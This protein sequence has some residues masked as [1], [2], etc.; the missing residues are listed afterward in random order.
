MALFVLVATPVASAA[1]QPSPL[2]PGDIVTIVET[3]GFLGDF[4]L[5]K[6]VKVDPA[7]RVESTLS[8][9]SDPSQGPTAGP[10]LS[11]GPPPKFYAAVAVENT[12]AVFVAH[13]TFG[14]NG[15][16]ALFHV[17]PATGVRT[18]VSDFGDASQGPSQQRTFGIRELA[19]EPSGD[20]LVFYPG[21]LLIRV[22]RSTGMRTIVGD[23]Q[24]PA[25]GPVIEPTAL[26]VEE[27]GRILVGGLGGVVRVDPSTGTRALLSDFG[28]PEQGPSARLGSDLTVDP[29]GTILIVG[30]VTTL[31]PDPF[32]LLRVDPVTGTRSLVTELT[33]S[34]L[35]ANIPFDLAM[36]ETGDVVVVTGVADLGQ[37]LMRVDSVTG[38][39]AGRAGI[40]GFLKDVAVVPTPLVNGMVSLSVV[41]TTLEPS[42]ADP[43][44]PAGVFQITATLSNETATPIRN[45]FFRVAELSGGNV[46]VSGDGPPD[47]IRAGGKGTRQTPHVGIEG[48]L[49]PG[50]SVT[51]ELEIGLQTRQPFTFFVNVF[52]EPDTS[53]NSP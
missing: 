41:G 12:A 35:P 43:F 16:G 20:L 45:P 13:P 9:F 1:Q 39:C 50:E 34:T 7:T 17:D 28:N 30:P 3:A 47:L 33:C 18:I 31:P 48:V 24:D 11:P 27:S 22:N 15:Q 8:H 46:L 14:T 4:P 44:A 52:G 10:P 2:R 36:E 26:A 6:L 49:F 42:S 23:F 29:S 40:S 5:G 51:V 21:P 19:I 37:D 38:Q 25:Q 32:R 53:L